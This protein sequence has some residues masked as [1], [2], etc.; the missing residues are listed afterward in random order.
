[1]Q[2]DARKAPTSE[3]LQDFFGPSEEVSQSAPR[4]QRGLVVGAA[5]VLL[6]GIVFGI[7]WAAAVAGSPSPSPWLY[8][9]LYPVGGAAEVTA[10]AGS[11]LPGVILGTPEFATLPILFAYAFPIGV[12]HA[13][14]V[15]LVV[16]GVI[17]LVHLFRE[18]YPK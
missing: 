5:I 10:T 16:A 6:Y 8:A 4:W 14:I 7:V 15:A 12:A 17:R 9:V 3:D 13:T 11:V 18:R 2:A 1:M